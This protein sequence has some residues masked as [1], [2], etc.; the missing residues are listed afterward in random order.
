[1]NMNCCFGVGKDFENLS[2]SPSHWFSSIFLSATDKRRCSHRTWLP[3]SLLFCFCSFSLLGFVVYISQIKWKGNFVL[4]HPR[5]ILNYHPSN[6][7]CLLTC[8]TSMSFG[9]AQSSPCWFAFL[10]VHGRGLELGGP[11]FTL[12]WRSHYFLDLCWEPS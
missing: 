10:I 1:M 6:F 11:N 9:G 7:S 2:A 12:P 5:I 8:S 4:P 3:P